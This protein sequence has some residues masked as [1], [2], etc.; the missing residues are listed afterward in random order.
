MDVP[1]LLHTV[2][3]ILADKINSNEE[4]EVSKLFAIDALEVEERM[5][6]LQETEL[7]G[8]DWEEMN[9]ETETTEK[10]DKWVWCE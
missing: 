7:E 10:A 5:E 8:G 9:E 6:V 2:G 3:E 1:A 4:T